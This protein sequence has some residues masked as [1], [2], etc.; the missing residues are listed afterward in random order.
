M[1]F[2]KVISAA[3]S[4]AVC[5]SMTMGMTVSAAEVSYDEG[6]SAVAGM[7]A[8]DPVWTECRKL[9][10]A[11]YNSAYVKMARK[12]SEKKETKSIFYGKSRTKN[13]IDKVDKA[14]GKKE[15]NVSFTLINE[16]IILSAAVKGDKAMEVVY[17]NDSPS[18]GIAIYSDPKKATVLNAET[19]LMAVQE[20]DWELDASGL[21]ESSVFAVV[22]TSV[23][24]AD[25]YGKVFKFTYNGKNYVYE[26]FSDGIGGK[27]GMLFDSSNKPLAVVSNGD[28]CCCSFSTSVKDSVF[29][30]PS[31][32]TEVEL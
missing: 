19:K 4:L 12:Y 8:A 11:K 18:L 28:V 16:D 31:G 24:P 14:F 10:G 6:M 25:A 22:S 9:T 2:K 1:K 23:V 5:C 13:F 15:L 29:K 21:R 17:T 32:Y 3:V 27:L 26:E 30:I 20:R 7:Y